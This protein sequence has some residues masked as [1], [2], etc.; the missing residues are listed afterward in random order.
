M[1]ARHLA[2]AGASVAVVLATRRERLAA[3]T[4]EQSA[5]LERMGIPIT[6]CHEPAGEKARQLAVHGSIAGTRETHHF[7]QVEAAI[8][9]AEKEG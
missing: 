8:G 9:R 2:V 5:I 4:A 3:V 7:V 1:A 6:E